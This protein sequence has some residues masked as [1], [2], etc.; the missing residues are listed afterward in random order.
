MH[1]HLRLTSRPSASP[2]WLYSQNIFP[3]LIISVP[4]TSS[5]LVWAPVISQLLWCANFL[6]GPTLSAIS[7]LRS[8]PPE[9]ARE[10]LIK[11]P[12]EHNPPRRKI[13]LWS[14]NSLRVK[15][16][17]WPLRPNVTQTHHYI[18]DLLSYY[19]P[20]YSHRSNGTACP[21]VLGTHVLHPDAIWASAAPSTLL[22]PHSV[23]STPV[24]LIYLLH[25]FSPL[26][27][28]PLSLPFTMWRT[29]KQASSCALF[30]PS[31][32]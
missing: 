7:S 13:L 32:L 30:F 10:I 6:T 15:S 23:R 31:N 5:S 27:A 20:G 11:C 18:S 21:A 8:F 1:Q 22:K 3:N 19:S 16:P 25:F 2:I 12:S 14:P 29:F 9:Q 17:Q 28:P 4:A 26:P 24:S